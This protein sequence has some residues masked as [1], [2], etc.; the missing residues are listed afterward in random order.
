[1]QS[2]N[3]E[4]LSDEALLT[5]CLWAEARGEPEEGQ[6]AVCNVILNR[7]RKGMAADLR[8]VILK[9]RQFSW[10]DPNDPNFPKVFTAANDA[11]QSWTRALRIAKRALAGTLDDLS[12]DADHYLNVELTRKLRGGTLPSWVDLDKVTVKIGN[13]TFL[14]LHA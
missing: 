10:T 5:A 1:M 3:L 4:S 14:R 6:Q 7:V 12:K 8:A 9:P 13:H 11:P 2:S